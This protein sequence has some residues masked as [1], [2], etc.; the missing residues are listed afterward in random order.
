MLKRNFLWLI[1][2][3]LL[4]VTPIALF[5]QERTPIILGQAL[6]VQF[7]TDTDE[8]LFDYNLPESRTATFQVIGA[9]GLP[10]IQITQN[11]TVVSELISSSETLIRLTTLLP[12]G[13]Y[14]IRVGAS[15]IT[16]DVASVIIVLETE[17]A[18]PSL[19]LVLHVGVNGQVDSLNPLGLYTFDAIAEPLYLYVDSLITEHG[20]L[21]ELTNTTLGI[22]TARITADHTGARLRIPAGDSNFQLTVTHSGSASPERYTVCL[23]TVALNNCVGSSEI[24]PTVATVP[25][26]VTDGCFVVPGVQG[27]VNIRQSDSTAAPILGAL[28]VSQRAQVIGIS[29]SGLFYNVTYN[30]LN[31]WVAVSVVVADGDCANLPVNI[32]PA[33]PPTAVP[34]QPPAPTAPPVQ[35]TQPPP[36]PTA[37]PSG[38]CLL[39]VLQ[40]SF[41][42]VIPVELI[43]HLQDQ[44]QAG[45]QLIPV[46][47]LADNSW[48][49]TNYANAWVQTSL[50]GSSIQVSGDCS[51]LPIVTP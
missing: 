2:V 10:R 18:V 37:T 40:P 32:P 27:S 16:A 45:G 48:W 1:L 33:L 14:E 15:Q 6:A 50:F 23:T 19:E 31:G 12:A 46:G 30:G 44:I 7:T 41:V 35:P 13:D 28:P 5:A 4:A 20:S 38:P 47:R 17:I 36:Q 21:V 24:L 29:P 22:S 42:Y 26:E 3:M 8:A 11:G 25:T 9:G 34:T 51:G 43:D 39:N 49:R